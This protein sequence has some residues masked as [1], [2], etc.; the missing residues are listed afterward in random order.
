MAIVQ[1]IPGPGFNGF[2]RRC[3]FFVTVSFRYHFCLL[4]VVLVWIPYC[5]SPTKIMLCQ[6]VGVS[7]FEG[8]CRRRDKAGQG[9]LGLN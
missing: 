8:F 7:V 2:S 5:Y 9:D 1:N 6:D 3:M 4:F